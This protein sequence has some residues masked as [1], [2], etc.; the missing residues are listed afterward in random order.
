MFL[1]LSSF[2]FLLM[3]FFLFLVLVLFLFLFTFL[4]FSFVHFSLFC[5]FSLSGVEARKCGRAEWAESGVNEVSRV[6][7]EQLRKDWKCAS[8]FSGAE[9]RKCGRAEWAESGV[10]EV[11]RVSTKSL[12]Q[13]Q[14]LFPALKP[15][16]A[17][18]EAGRPL[19]STSPKF[20]TYLVEWGAPLGKSFVASPV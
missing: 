1:F 7:A 13:G 14:V 6:Y 19:A 18:E 15:E 10:N 20:K 8:A 2:L 16:S 4:F 5:L 11:S 17:G 12:C 9:A 3:L